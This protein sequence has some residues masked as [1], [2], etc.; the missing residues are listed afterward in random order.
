MN[1]QL[2]SGLTGLGI[3]AVGGLTFLAGLGSASTAGGL[4]NG[5]IKSSVL[6]IADAV[7]KGEAGADKQAAALA[8]KIEDLDD[9][10]A[11]FKKRDK[12]GLGVGS[13][14]GVATP[15]GI[16]V[17]L[18]ALGRDAPSGATLKKE[19]EALEEMGYVIAAM[20][21]IAKH[22]PAAKAGKDW[23]TWCDDMSA[24]GLKLS[25]AAKSQTAADVKTLASKINTTCNACHSMYR[26]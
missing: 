14:P 12:E 17:K 1:K 19:A 3:L 24:T 11:M 15:D 21:K 16:E 13:K 22:K 23:N 7:K 26:K 2:C 6:K 18:V 10:M 25:A 4:D 8:K 5:A 9:L 20:G